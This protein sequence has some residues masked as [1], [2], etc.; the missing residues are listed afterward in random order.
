MPIAHTHTHIHTRYLH[1]SDQLPQAFPI[2]LSPS[3]FPLSSILS[4]LTLPAAYLCTLP[5]YSPSKSPEYPP[6]SEITIFCF[7][8]SQS[9][10]KVSI[11]DGSLH[12]RYIRPSTLIGEFASNSPNT[13]HTE[14][15]HTH[16]HVV[17][18]LLLTCP[19][20]LTIYLGTLLISDHLL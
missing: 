18:F 16:I 5:T 13:F 9:F 10:F 17:C 20:C 12:A 14:F 19:A 11:I 3:H 8:S 1:I 15:K 6:R 7:P 2:L 4:I